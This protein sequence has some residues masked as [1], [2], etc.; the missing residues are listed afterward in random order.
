MS[1]KGFG[2]FSMETNVREKEQVEGI[3]GLLSEARRCDNEFI[4]LVLLIHI[5]S[6]CTQ[7]IPPNICPWV[8]QALY[9]LFP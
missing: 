6:F 1:S 7:Q 3:E 4:V 8:S 5:F 9:Q 2:A